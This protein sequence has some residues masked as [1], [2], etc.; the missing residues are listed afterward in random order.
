MFPSVRRA[1]DGDVDRIVTISALCFSNPWQREA[2]IADIARSWTRLL[3]VTDS[4]H[5]V[6][7]VH[8]WLVAGEVQVMNVA[9]DPTH[10]RRGLGRALVASML[11]DARENRCETV[12]LEVRAANHAA[13]ALYASFGF[14]QT[15]VRE[16]YYDDG[17]DA[18][19]MAAR[20]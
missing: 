17:E 15:G 6:G 10:R 20:L 12:L 13:I 5:V 19:L 4:E 7:F 16:R 8:Y 11:D 18:V 1:A 9:T 14:A 2:F 3:V